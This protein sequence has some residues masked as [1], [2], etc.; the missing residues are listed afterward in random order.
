[1][2]KYG[3]G[4]TFI[5]MAQALYQCPSVRVRTN[6]YL[7]ETNL[8]LTASLKVKNRKGKPRVSNPWF[9]DSLNKLKQCSCALERKLQKKNIW[10]IM[11]K[12]NGRFILQMIKRLFLMQRNPIPQKEFLK[13]LINQR[14]YLAL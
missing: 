12:Y 13:Q 1:M 8:N 10:I 6:G 5:Q 2:G 11:M 14:I 7:S 9:S 3:L 4:K